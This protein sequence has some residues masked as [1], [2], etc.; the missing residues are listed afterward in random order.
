MR[1]IQ[2]F[3]L[4]RSGESIGYVNT[5]TYF[6]EESTTPPQNC[7]DTWL[8]IDPFTSP[9]TYERKTSS[10]DQLPKSAESAGEDVLRK[11]RLTGDESN[12]GSI[13]E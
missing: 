8:H 12:W 13:V 1:G 9:A 7:S 6:P 11:C 5:H 10:N 3:A 2:K 4:L